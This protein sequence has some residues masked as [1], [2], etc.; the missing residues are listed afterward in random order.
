MMR[1]IF[2]GSGKCLPAI[3]GDE[4]MSAGG[5]GAFEE[6]IVVF[7]RTCGGYHPGS[8]VDRFPAQQPDEPPRQGGIDMGKI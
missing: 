2:H 4:V 7:V 1:V 5:L 6:S 8:D 3:A